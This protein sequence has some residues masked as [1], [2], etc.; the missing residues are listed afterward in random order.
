MVIWVQFG[1]NSEK[2]LNKNFAKFGLKKRMEMS[3]LETNQK[4]NHAFSAVT[5]IVLLTFS[6]FSIVCVQSK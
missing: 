1:V 6:L 3:N 2:L 4:R 5:V